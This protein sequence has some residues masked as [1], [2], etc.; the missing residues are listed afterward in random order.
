MKESME[1]KIETWVYRGNGGF[2]VYLSLVSKE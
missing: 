1:D 2:R